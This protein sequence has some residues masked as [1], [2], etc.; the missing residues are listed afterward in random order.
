MEWNQRYSTDLNNWLAPA[1]TLLT[2][3]ENMLSGDGVAFEAAMGMGNNIQFLID[4]QYRVVCADRS[5][6]AVKHVHIHFPSA[7]VILT[8][9][10]AFRMPPNFFDL[11]CNFYYFEMKLWSQFVKALKPGGILMVETLTEKMLDF[12]PDIDPSRLLKPGTL[13]R[14]FPGLEILYQSEGWTTSDKG[15]QKAIASLVAR[16]PLK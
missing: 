11:I 13:P 1:R 4:H 6:V 10:S 2:D 7:D 12:R 16:K 15:H 3:H 14:L 8:D 5:E 9:L